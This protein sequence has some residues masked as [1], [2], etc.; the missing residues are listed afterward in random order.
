MRSNEG[1]IGRGNENGK[2]QLSK[3]AFLIMPLI[4]LT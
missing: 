1:N 2:G 3:I 4:S